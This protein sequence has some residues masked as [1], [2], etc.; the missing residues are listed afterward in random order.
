MPNNM[1]SNKVEN[2][3]ATLEEN[4]LLLI[5]KSSFLQFSTLAYY[6][7]QTLSILGAM[8]VAIQ[9]YPAVEL[10][11]SSCFKIGSGTSAYLRWMMHF[12]SFG[13][14]SLC[15]GMVNYYMNIALLEDY[16]AR[17]VNNQNNK[18][19]NV[20]KLSISE[21]LQYWGGV[22]IFIVTGILYGCMAFA[23][24]MD[25]PLAQL[26]ILSGFFV[27]AVMTIQ[28]VE[29]WI[30]KFEE[31]YEN[32]EDITSELSHEQ[33]CGEFWGQ[34]IAV[35]NVIALSLLFSLSLTQTL[36]ALEVAA[37]PS[38]G[39]G[40]GVAFTFG[41]FTEYYFYYYFLGKFC[42]DFSDNLNNML[43]LPNANLGILCI[44]LNAFVNSA[45]TYSGIMM[46]TGLFASANIILPPSAIMLLLAGSS[47]L[48]A[49]AASFLLGMDFWLSQNQQSNVT[50]NSNNKNN[51]IISHSS[52]FG[53]NTS[54]IGSKNLLSAT[55][56]V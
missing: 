46:L 23:F 52:F 12:A 29:T 13:A 37:L 5:E 35:G 56:A 8:G 41:A 22:L 3:L 1:P 10:F 25:G 15:G 18:K 26:S 19:F 9:N 49:G 21:Q 16:F 27:S 32:K 30:K 33:V 11:L 36:M 48:C 53:V 42:R 55:K 2:S 34:V 47:A 40:L 51:S 6:S 50:E 24:S 20:N 43:Q 7:A 14:G 28:E 39:I 54:E 31:F 44:F 45:L 4:N 17:L 38:L